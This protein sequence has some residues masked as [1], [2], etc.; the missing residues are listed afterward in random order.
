MNDSL[1]AAGSAVVLATLALVVTGPLGA[2]AV[3]VVVLAV[4]LGVGL[5][6]GGAAA[7]PSRVNCPHCGARTDDG[8][9]CGYCGEPL[10]G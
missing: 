4:G 2:L 6:T 9:A 3:G 10:D 5:P 7:A 8:D 1:V